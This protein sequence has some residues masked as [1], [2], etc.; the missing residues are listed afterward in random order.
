MRL[1]PLPT[2]ENGRHFIEN[3]GEKVPVIQG[4]VSGNQVTVTCPCCKSQHTHGWD[5]KLKESAV[6]LRSSHCSS[7]NYSPDAAGLSQSSYYITKSLKA[8]IADPDNEIQTLGISAASK[9]TVPAID[10]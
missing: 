1:Q 3:S 7:K 9:H 5:P 2:N 10:M 4:T 6:D 8:A